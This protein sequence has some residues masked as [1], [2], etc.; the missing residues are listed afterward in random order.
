VVDLADAYNLAR[1]VLERR[2]PQDYALIGV[3]YQP[4][5]MGDNIIGDG[6]LTF[7]VEVEGVVE[8]RPEY[9]RV[10]TQLQGKPFEE[11]MT[12]LD[13]AWQRGELPVAAPPQAEIWP[14]WAEGRFPWLIWRIEVVEQDSTGVLSG[15][16]GT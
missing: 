7:F 1:H 15:A 13:A 4:G 12:L 3:R 8:A 6:T 14:T 11:G 9:T 10:K 16:P 2:V 5:L